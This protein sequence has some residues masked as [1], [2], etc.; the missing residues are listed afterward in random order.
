MNS[1]LVSLLLF[2]FF[3]SL[4]LSSSTN[5]NGSSNSN[6]LSSED[7]DFLLDFDEELE[8]VEED[9]KNQYICKYVCPSGKSLFFNLKGSN[10]E[11]LYVQKCLEKKKEQIQNKL[12]EIQKFGMEYSCG[13]SNGFGCNAI[14]QSERALLHNFAKDFKRLCEEQQTKVSPFKL[15]NDL[16]D[17]STFKQKYEEI[18]EKRR[19]AVNQGKLNPKYLGY[20]TEIEK[21]RKEQV[22]ILSEPCPCEQIVG[23]KKLP[24][25]SK[26]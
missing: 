19:E 18:K 4:V 20:Y 23:L 9:C 1:K 11:S 3:V 22:A 13:I 25:G 21:F 5:C 26:C 16:W 15:F 6:A 8:S 14:F 7:S 24:N 17:K 2:S 10:Y 12:G